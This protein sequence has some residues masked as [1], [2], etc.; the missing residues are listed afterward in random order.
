MIWVAVEYLIVKGK[1]I[2]AKDFLKFLRDE[3]DQ[4]SNC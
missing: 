3:H 2:K 4:E 1:L